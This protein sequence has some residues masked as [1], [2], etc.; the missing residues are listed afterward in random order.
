[1]V[2]STVGELTGPMATWVADVAGAPVRAARRVAAGGR[3]HGYVVELADGR[4]VFLTQQVDASTA[5]LPSLSLASEARLLAALSRT[6]VPAPHILG[7]SPD[8]LAMLA[9]LVPGTASY[10][11]LRDESVRVTVARDFMRCLAELHRV[12]PRQLDVPE[13]GQPGTARQHLRQFLDTWEKF[14]RAGPNGSDVL[15]EFG[16]SWLRDHVPNVEA[17]AAIVQG[18]TGPGNFMFDGDRVTAILDWELA[19]LGDP[20]EDLG[21]L[22]MRCAQEPFP[23]FAARLLEY[24]NLSG[25]PLD[26]DRLRYY[27]VL[28]EWTIALVG[29]LKP[30]R[31]LGDSE[32][33]NAIVFETLHRRL[34]IEA[35]AE[36]EG[37]ELAPVELP[38]W[39]DTART[40][41]FDMAL[42]QLRESVLPHVDHPLAARR[43]KGVARVIKVLREADRFGGADERAEEESLRRLVSAGTI[44]RMR[45]DLCERIRLRTVGKAGVLDHLWLL[46]SLENELMRPAMGRLADRHLDTLPTLGSP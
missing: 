30:R 17:A 9:T 18:D 5:R 22:S 43:T 13:F 25:R 37:L 34:T 31:G 42:D 6:A 7:V 19:H 35:I 39:A 8:G 1:M 33:G 14:Y 24:Q 27:R 41:L 46:V 15:I 20:L 45:Q 2:G 38:E 36:A 12:D 28:A 26:L 3:R 44:T 40:W 11:S 23:D 4:P 16:L 10:S 21:W 29:H 32:R